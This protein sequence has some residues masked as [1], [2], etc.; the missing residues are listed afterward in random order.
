[1]SEVGIIVDKVSEVL[2]IEEKSIR[3]T[4]NFG[5]RVDTEFI[6]GVGMAEARV[7][8]LLDIDKVLDADALS[9]AGS[10]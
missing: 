9:T 7:I 8:M 1:M 10:F 5:H 3:D 2:E 4:P 6:L